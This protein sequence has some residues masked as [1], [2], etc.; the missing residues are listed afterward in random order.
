M[1][2]KRRRIPEPHQV[3]TRQKLLKFSFKHLDTTKEK[4]GCDKCTQEYFAKLL[5]T[6]QRYSTWRVEEFTEQDHNEHRH[7]ISD[8]S[9]TSEPAGFSHISDDDLDQ[10]GYCDIWEIGVNPELP[11]CLWRAHGVLIEDTF[12]LVWFDPDHALY[13]SNKPVTA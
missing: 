2:K 5:Q 1:P 4:F 11:Y 8:F 6:L 9:T 10:F 12:F 13:P 3:P 7:V